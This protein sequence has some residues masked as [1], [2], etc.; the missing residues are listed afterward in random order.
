MGSCSS[1][2]TRDVGVGESDRRGSLLGM[3]AK[4]MLGTSQGPAEIDGLYLANK[5]I[6]KA[7]SMV[8]VTVFRLTRITAAGLNHPVEPP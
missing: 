4:F 3:M 1:S 8:P 6:L 2:D 7:L 5:V